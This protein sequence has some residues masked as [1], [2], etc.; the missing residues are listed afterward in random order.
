M[1]AI[2]I[3]DCK[4]PNPSFDPSKPTDRTVVGIN[5]DG[6]KVR[7]NWPEVDKP[8]G[9][10]IDHPDAHYLCYG[11]DPNA[12]PH[13]EECLNVFNEY[14][15]RREAGLAAREAQASEDDGEHEELQPPAAKTVQRPER[16]ADGEQ[17]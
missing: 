12:E 17:S 14:R 9:M 13:D 2:L 16:T 10:V 4:G 15:T 8:K 7:A 3:K 1:K 6:T 5:A 11:E